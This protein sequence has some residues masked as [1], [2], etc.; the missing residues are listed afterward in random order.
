MK[1][2]LL[3]AAQWS[4]W[5]LL[6]TSI[7]ILLHEAAH[8]GAALAVGVPEP[9]LHYSAISHGDLSG[10]P[11]WAFALTS[12]AGPLVTMALTLI[13]CLV[14]RND[15]SSRW[16]FGLAASASS[17]LLLGLPFAILGTISVMMGYGAESQFD[18]FKAASALGLPG[19][20]FVVLTAAYGVAAWAY[21]IR[22]LPRS[23]RWYA[24]S[25]L[26]I[27]TALGWGLWLAVLGPVLLP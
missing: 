16:G 1:Q 24:F 23:D 15:R 11:G 14:I 13:G 2:G 10:M 5:P 8:F 9:K 3:Q 27:G 7:G 17:R 18:E 21:L 6:L 19:L 22:R 4:I 25:G 26:V 12:V 20:P